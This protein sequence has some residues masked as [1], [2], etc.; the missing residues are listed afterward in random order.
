[1][2]T[3]T[4]TPW[5]LPVTGRIFS[6]QSAHRRLWGC[7]P[8]APAALNPRNIHGTRFCYRL[9]RLQGHSA[10]ERFRSIEKQIVDY[11]HLLTVV[12][13]SRIFLPWRWRRYVPPKRRFTQYLYGATSQKTVFFIVTAVKTSNLI[14]QKTLPVCLKKCVCGRMLLGIEIISL[15]VV[16]QLFRTGVALCFLWGNNSIIKYHLDEFQAL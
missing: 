8:D 14:I 7:Q 11:S 4:W 12:P 10:P 3:L 15:H 13:C 9:N 5:Q 2:S 1:V 16:I 6:R